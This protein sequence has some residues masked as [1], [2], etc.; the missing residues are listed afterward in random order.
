MKLKLCTIILA[1][2]A[3]AASARAQLTWHVIHTDEDSQ[4][5]FYFGSI[6]C[7]GNNCTVGAVLIDLTSDQWTPV[8][9]ESTDGGVTWI[10]QIPDVKYPF[11]FLNAGFRKI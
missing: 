7:S 11:T 4:T 1:L 8:L 3:F 6:S 2:A 5:Q 9:Y 10:M